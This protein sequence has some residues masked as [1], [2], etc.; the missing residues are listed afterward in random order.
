MD[1]LD[2]FFFLF[3]VLFSYPPDNPTFI[4]FR[5]TPGPNMDGL[6]GFYCN[7]NIYDEV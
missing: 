2:L 5:P 7:I 1:A 6:E 3:F 4:A